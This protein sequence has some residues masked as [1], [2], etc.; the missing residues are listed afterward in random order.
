MNKKIVRQITVHGSAEAVAIIITLLNAVAG[1]DVKNILRAVCA[2]F[3]LTVN[4]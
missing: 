2:Y 3:K 1:Y 4:E